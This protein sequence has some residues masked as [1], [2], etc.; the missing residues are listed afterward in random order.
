MPKLQQALFV[1]CNPMT[2]LTNIEKTDKI[3]MT[4]GQELL[5]ELSL[6]AKVTRRF[7]ESVPFDK[8]EYKPTEK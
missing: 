8:A 7:L 1:A 4:I 6:E 3:L 5:Q 2:A